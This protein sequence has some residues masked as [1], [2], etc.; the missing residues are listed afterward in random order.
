MRKLLKG[1]QRWILD[2]VDPVC[3]DK[4][5]VILGKYRGYCVKLHPLVGR[6]NRVERWVPDQKAADRIDEMLAD[7]PELEVEPPVFGTCPAPAQPVPP[8]APVTQPPV[9]P[10]APT[11]NP[12]GVPGI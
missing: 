4:A 12:N 2:A 1:I 10:N 9:L 3:Q 11:F 6:D 7:H 5:A 8:T